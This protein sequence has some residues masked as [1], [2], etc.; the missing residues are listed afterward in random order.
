MRA[1]FRSLCECATVDGRGRRVGEGGGDFPLSAAPL[2]RPSPSFM[3]QHKP[4]GHTRQG[5]GES[6][7]V[8]LERREWD[9][10]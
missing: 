9:D 1:C 6:P 5:E 7:A 3:R 8:G 4:V 2:C 10:L